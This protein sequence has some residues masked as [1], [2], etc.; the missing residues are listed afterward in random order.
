MNSKYSIKDIERLSGIKA[1][2]IRAWE[3]R[4]N[5]LEP[6]RTDTNIRYYADEH[7]KKILNIA[8][9]VKSGM[10]ISKVANLEELELCNAVLDNG[11]HESN[12][13]SQINSLKLAMLDYN[14]KLFDRVFESCINHVGIDETFTKILGEFIK[15]IGVLWHAGAITVGNE[16]FVTNLIKQKLY[17]FLDTVPFPKENPEKEVIFFLPQGELHELSMLYLNYYLKKDGYK[18][19]N[20]GQSVPLGY[21]KE[22]CIKANI[23]KMVTVVTTSPSFEDLEDYL[24]E[25][26]SFFKNY[27]FE[28]HI[29][30][31]QITDSLIQKGLKGINIYDSV[32]SIKSKFLK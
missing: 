10:K 1:H 18:V 2:T 22:A 30:G 21:L 6:H 17:G 12:F 28:L 9:L 31:M 24:V 20:L 7:L 29:S 27:G 4:Y 15:E 8:V 11:S 14:E 3:Q 32:E 16:H 25:F 13:S 5:L 23:F 19:V 26:E